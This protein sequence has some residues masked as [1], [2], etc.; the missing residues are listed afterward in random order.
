MEP[1]TIEAL[2]SAGAALLIL[3]MAIY[4][5]RHLAHQAKENRAERETTGV[6]HQTVITTIVDAHEKSMDANTTAVTELTKSIN[7]HRE[8]SSANIQKCEAVREKMQEA[9]SK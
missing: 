1:T 7:G 2:S 9:I 5:I 8:E 3:V 4:F 6:Q